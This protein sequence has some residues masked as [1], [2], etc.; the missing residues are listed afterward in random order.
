MLMV[1]QNKK[2]GGR[3]MSRLQQLIVCALLIGMVSMA[4]VM[5]QSTFAKPGT[6]EEAKK[7]NVVY[8]TK[9]GKK[10]HQKDCPFIA[11]RETTSMGKEE[12]EAQGLAPCGKCFKKDK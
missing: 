9:Q 4:A 12:A 2:T 6:Q 7:E 5:P 10:Y 1:S 3:T 11:K 8:V